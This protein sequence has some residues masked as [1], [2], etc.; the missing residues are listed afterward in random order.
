MSYIIIIYLIT[1]IIQYYEL[2]CANTFIETVQRNFCAKRLRS[3]F[4]SVMLHVLKIL[5]VS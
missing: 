5:S 1:Q 3:Q 4:H 2:K